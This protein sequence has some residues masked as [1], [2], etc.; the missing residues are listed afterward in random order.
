MTIL[1][2]L[3]DYTDA[4]DML[5]KTRPDFIDIVT[6]VE[7][8][9]LLVELAANAGVPAIC[10]KPFATNA[11]DA[12]GMVRAC[13]SAGVPLMVHE[14]FRW[15]APIRELKRLLESGVIGTPFFGRVSFRHD[16]D[17]YAGQPYLAEGDRL[18]I[19]DVGIHILDIARFLFGEA[20]RLSCTTQ[21]VNPRVKGE[22]AA[23]MLLQHASGATSVVDC[24]FF[25]HLET[26]PFPQ[27]VVEI[28]GSDGT[29]RLGAGYGLV[30][31]ARGKTERRNLDPMPAPWMERPWHVIQDSVVSIQRH[32]VEC[33]TG[34]E[35]P[36]TSGADNFKTLHLGLLAYD[37][38]ASG[39][40]LQV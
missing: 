26:N 34:G 23:T 5:T 18:A 31:A 20:T 32:W 22:D 7:S 36:L 2:I 4:A 15:Q 35:T 16:Y 11:A 12:D 9:R 33:L 38:A 17:I 29:I 21:R 40:T 27:T 14:N 39:L 37:A 6:T 28:D 10:Q 3:R 13:E 8:H 19:L 24:S 1:N 30:V 25:S